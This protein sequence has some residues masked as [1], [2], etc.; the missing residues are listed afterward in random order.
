MLYGA[1]FYDDIM[2]PSAFFATQDLYMYEAKSE[3]LS[4]HL[5]FLGSENSVF[6]LTI[7]LANSSVD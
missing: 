7:W 4:L 6:G 5:E 2:L 3:G 1:I